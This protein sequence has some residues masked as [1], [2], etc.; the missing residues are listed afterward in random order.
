LIFKELEAQLQKNG[1]TI[2][3]ATLPAMPTTIMTRSIKQE[4]I[5]DSNSPINTPSGSMVSKS[6]SYNP[7]LINLNVSIL[8]FIGIHVTT[9]GHYCSHG[10]HIA[11]CRSSPSPTYGTIVIL[12]CR[13]QSFTRLAIIFDTATAVVIEQLATTTTTTALS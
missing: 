1:I 13:K 3:P 9:I 4:P 7:A 5:D 6:A 12:Q 11:N 10:N 8:V 2:P